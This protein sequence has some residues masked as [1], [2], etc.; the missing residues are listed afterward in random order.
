LAETAR[1]AFNTADNPPTKK[2]EL[3]DS[4]VDKSVAGELEMWKL[5]SME[6]SSQLNVAWVKTMMS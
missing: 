3:G 1:D 5:L 6:Y 2:R 4:S